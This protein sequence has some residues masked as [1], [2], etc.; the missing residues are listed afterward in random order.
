MRYDPAL[1]FGGA[2]GMIGMAGGSDTPPTF[3]GAL[4]CSIAAALGGD[5]EARIVHRE[6]AADLASLVRLGLAARAPVGPPRPLYL[7]AP[8][9]KPQQA[10]A[11]ARR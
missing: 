5:A 3:S 11:V 9:A 8:D 7:R 6:A 2:G 1:M 10:A 4:A